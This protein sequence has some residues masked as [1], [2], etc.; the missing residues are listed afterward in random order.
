MYGD[1]RNKDYPHL[2]YDAAWGHFV[3]ENCNIITNLNSVAECKAEALAFK[4]AH[5]DCK[6]KGK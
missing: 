6:K 2:R 1:Q 3:C 4:N 5:K